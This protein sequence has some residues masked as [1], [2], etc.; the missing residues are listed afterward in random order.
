MRM[1][2]AQTA[3][4]M[5]VNIVVSVKTGGRAACATKISMSVTLVHATTVEHA[6]MRS[7]GTSAC[8]RKAGKARSVKIREICV[9]L[10]YKRVTRWPLVS[11]RFRGLSNATACQATWAMRS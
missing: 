7:M 6:K 10:A 3:A 8:A 5:Q 4:L 1:S 11:T 9:P 2:Q